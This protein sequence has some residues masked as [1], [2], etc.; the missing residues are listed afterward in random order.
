MARY[1]SCPRCSSVG[2]VPTSPRW[3]WT[4]DIEASFQI[5]SGCS[6]LGRVRAD[7]A[8]P[9]DS[10][11]EKVEDKKVMRVA[12]STYW[13]ASPSRLNIPRIVSDWDR[14]KVRPLAPAAS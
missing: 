13:P 14:I 10:A 8:V 11:V 6:G 9:K 4:N 2:I 1:I 3:E 12:E 5:C 7:V